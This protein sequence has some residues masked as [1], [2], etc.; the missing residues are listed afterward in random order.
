MSILVLFV[1][2]ALVWLCAWAVQNLVP[3]EAAGQKAIT[4]VAVVATV[5]V[6]LYALGLLPSDLRVPRFR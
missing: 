1:W 5:L 4:V 2:I 3:M 6:C